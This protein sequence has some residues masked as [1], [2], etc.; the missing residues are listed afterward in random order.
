M[1]VAAGWNVAMRVAGGCKVV[2]RGAVAA[3]CVARRVAVVA[4]GWDVGRGVAVAAR[5]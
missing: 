4:V 1:A 3:R 5:W 2:T